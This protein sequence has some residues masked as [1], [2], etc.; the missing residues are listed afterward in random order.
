MKKNLYI[1][2]LSLVA[3]F[4]SCTKSQD[5]IPPTDQNY[6]PE[7]LIKRIRWPK[8]NTL[9]NLTYNTDSTLKQIN[10]SNPSSPVVS[11]FYQNKKIKEFIQSGSIYATRCT[12]NN[13]GQMATMTREIMDAPGQS[14]TTL[15]LEFSYNSHDRLSMMKNYWVNASGNK[16]MHTVNY[17]Y[18]TQLRPEKITS[19]EQSGIVT[20]VSIKAYSVLVSFNPLYFIDTGGMTTINADYLIYNHPILSRL[21]QLPSLITVTRIENGKSNLEQQT[22]ISYTINNLKLEK[23]ITERAFPLTP[24]LNDVTEMKYD[25]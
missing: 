23:Q 16:L 17:E 1:C 19:I 8:I 9:A 10:Y 14:R 11:F 3:G 25:Y 20:I 15:R 5:P 22:K 13:N 4:S 12:Y 21:K 7:F 24:Q 18:D 2:M 6:K